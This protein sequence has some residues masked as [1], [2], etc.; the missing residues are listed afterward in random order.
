MVHGMVGGMIETVCACC[1]LLPLLMLELSFLLVS[2]SLSPTPVM[3]VGGVTDG[4]SNQEG[5]LP[6]QK[7]GTEGKGEEIGRFYY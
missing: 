1:Q 3:T 7:T 4:G 6:H 2:I 5:F